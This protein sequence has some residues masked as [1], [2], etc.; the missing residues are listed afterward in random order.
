MTVTVPLPDDLA[1]RL[2]AA[3]AERGITPEELLVEA[4]EAHLP[5]PRS[6]VGIGASGRGDLSE[7]HTEIRRELISLQ[8]RKDLGS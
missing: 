3:A 1:A 2:A 4:V 5:R 7:R 8:R 6:F